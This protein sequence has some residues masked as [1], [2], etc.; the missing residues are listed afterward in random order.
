PS[1][2][3]IATGA[4]HDL[5][6]GLYSL[7]S[8]PAGPCPSVRAPNALSDRSPAGYANAASQG[9]PT[10]RAP[11]AQSW[12]L[13][14]LRIA[15]LI[16]RWFLGRRRCGWC[17]G[18]CA[19]VAR[20]VQRQPRVALYIDGRTKTEAR[21]VRREGRMSRVGRE[22]RV[23]WVLRVLR[24]RWHTGVPRESLFERAK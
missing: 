14:L 8:R 4:P 1:Q 15:R 3:A 17:G 10:R 19:H 6:R 24:V 12:S 16:A 11:S 2:E 20:S 13:V 22:V 23:F 7:A 9:P 5:S 21:M 18:R